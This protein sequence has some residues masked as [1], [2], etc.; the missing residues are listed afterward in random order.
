MNIPRIKHSIK[1]VSDIDLNDPR[2]I[3]A[4]I[5]PVYTDKF[6]Q[7]YYAFGL[8]IHN[9]FITDFGGHIEYNE[10][11]I[12]ENV[13]EAAVREFY[14]ESYGVFNNDITVESIIKNNY[15]VLDAVTELDRNGYSIGSL[16]ILVP[17]DIPSMKQIKRDFRDLINS[18]S[19]SE[20]VENIGIVWIRHDHL[21]K[22]Y[23]SEH[24]IRY[25]NN[26]QP[27]YTYYKVLMGLSKW[28]SDQ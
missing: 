17:V 11:G 6:G 16:D 14:E 1:R 18:L 26:S 8:S 9:G 10:F 28:V 22:I 25:H 23:K 5:I 2:Y 4:G 20:N 27:F 15:E 21:I 7:S 24:P 12:R 3:R 13:I 19:E